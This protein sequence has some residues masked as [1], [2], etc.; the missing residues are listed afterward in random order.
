MHFNSSTLSPRFEL[1]SKALYELEPNSCSKTWDS[2]TL[3][4]SLGSPDRKK[5]RTP[6]GTKMKRKPGFTLIELLVVIAI[7]AILVGLLMPAVQAAREAG[8]RTSCTNNLKQIGLALHSYHDT[9]KTFPSGFLTNAD[10]RVDPFA[11]LRPT[12]WGWFA[13]TLPYIEK[14]NLSDQIEWGESIDSTINAEPRNKTYPEFFCPSDSAIVGKTFRFSNWGGEN[15]WP[16]A[17]P[18]EIWDLTAGATNYVA[19]L[20]K[21]KEAARF[22]P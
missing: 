7:I 19:V 16:G 11:E 12:G 1:K 17:D 15:Q 18:D 22:D 8:R 5:R 10:V 13:L 6:P 21:V 9:L 20:S 2:A 14:N 4:F 3:D